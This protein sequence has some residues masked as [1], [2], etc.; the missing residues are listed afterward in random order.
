MSP[1]VNEILN[2]IEWNSIAGMVMVL[3]IVAIM[4]L[5][6]PILIIAV[7]FYFINKS[8]KP[9]IRIIWILES[10]IITL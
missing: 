3:C 4:F 5:L 1:D 2:G 7:I 6:S 8:K 9:L 10:H